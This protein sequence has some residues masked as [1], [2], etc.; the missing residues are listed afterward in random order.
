MFLLSG[1]HRQEQ[2]AGFRPSSFLGR[3]RLIAA[4]LLNVID[5]DYPHLRDAYFERLVDQRGAFKRT[6][7]HRFQSFDAAIIEAWT[8]QGESARPVRILDVAVSDG[9]TTI[10]LVDQLD[11]VIDGSFVVDATDLNTGYIVLQRATE[12]HRRV[13]ITPDGDIVQIVFPPFVFGNTN[14]RSVLLF[15]INRM[16]RAF[17]EKFARQMIAGFKAKE[18]A[19][20]ASPLAVM[21]REFGR[22][23]EQDKRISFV[24]W[25]VLDP[26]PGPQADVVRAMNLLN[27]GYF[28]LEQQQAVFKNLRNATRDG[29]LLAIGSNGDPDSEVEGTIYQRRYDYLVPLKSTAGGCRC[30]QA[31]AMF[32]PA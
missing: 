32:E 18:P 1:I 16:A 31:A 25:N 22:R 9:S 29:G 30:S 15:P 11:Q 14:F 5:S 17:A 21:N 3:R 2:L 10:D 23:L 19:I 12:R 20:S 27:P 4:D 24:S 13:I 26:W 8:A 7:R 28:T 6:Y